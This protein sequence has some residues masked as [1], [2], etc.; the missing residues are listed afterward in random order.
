[1]FKTRVIGLFGILG[2]VLTL[3]G[4]MEI[5][6]L[7]ESS[8]EQVR[9][10]VAGTRSSLA[11][12]HDA[13]WTRQELVTTILAEGELACAMAALTEVLQDLLAAQAEAFKAAP[14]TDARA[15]EIRERYIREV[16]KDGVSLPDFFASR[17]AD[18]LKRRVGPE[19]FEPNGLDAF[20]RDEADRFSKCAGVGGV[21]Q[22]MW[23]Y[24]YNT[25]P[26]AFAA[27]A[28]R[29]GLTVDQRVFVVGPAG[30]GLADS[31]N[32]RW[33]NEADFGAKTR[34]PMKAMQDE[35]KVR[36][37]TLIGDRYFMATSIPIVWD[38]R[39][40]GAVLV[41]DEVG[42]RM[43][44]EDSDIVGADVL[45]SMGGK[46]IAAPLP[47]DLA[48]RLASDLRSEEERVTASFSLTGMEWFEDLRV[49]VSQDMNEMTAAYN[50][51]STTLLL[52]GLLTTLLAVGLLVWLLRSFYGSFEV[53]DQGVHEV[54]NG[55]FDYQFPFE[56]RD[57]LARGFGQSLNLMSLVLQG[58][59]LPEEVE[60]ESGKTWSS[61]IQVL[62]AGDG[63]AEWGEPE[64]PLVAMTRDAIRA[65]ANEPADVY[66]KRL[67]SE[68]LDARRS[69]G[70]PVEGINYPKF[71]ERL[72]HL[73]QR[74]KKRHRASMIRFEVKTINGTVILA[75]V[76]IQKV[77]R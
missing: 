74:L 53:L 47:L 55:N 58:R 49:S 69:L 15:A 18:N 44:R 64:R 30:V 14:G 59:P 23:D 11:R 3:A 54:I 28:G 6:R 22:C 32:P 37:L 77:E 12:A 31:A 13:R 29:R 21:N 24:T 52:V 38:G 50:A 51:A 43:A 40:L 34:L 2:A 67:Y 72:V 62:D 25:L 66:Y 73:E 41:G 75:P 5:E 19:A 17:F 9:R 27:M 60:E 4:V 36:G 42:E 1:M 8:R 33:S 45:Y 63:G 68:F 39:V 20:L 61:E 56:F 26:K 65:L 16:R 7:E 48:N 46:V 70:L 76:P 35:V 57:D 71:L 10:K